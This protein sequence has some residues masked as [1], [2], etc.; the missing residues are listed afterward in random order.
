MPNEN[1]SLGIRVLLSGEGGASTLLTVILTTGALL[2]FGLILLGVI[3]RDGDLSATNYSHVRAFYVAESAIEYAYRKSVESLDESAYPEVGSNNN[4]TTICHIPPGN[5]AN[6]HTISVGNGAVNAHLNHGDY[7]GPCDFSD[8]DEG[9]WNWS[10]DDIPVEGGTADVLVFTTPSN[11]P[12]DLAFMHDTISIVSLGKFNGTGARLEYR[13]KQVDY[14]F[15][16]VYTTGAQLDISVLDHWGN[17]SSQRQIQWEDTPAMMPKLNL[18]QIEQDAASQ[19]HKILSSL[20]LSNNQVY[21]SGEN[22][23]YFSGG[24]PNVTWIEGN[25]NLS[26]NAKIYGIVIVNGSIT[27]AENAT[28]EGVLFVRDGGATRTC[29]LENNSRING[30]LIGFTSISGDN[31]DQCRVFHHKT[32]L[33]RFYEYS[34]EDSPYNIFW[35]EWKQF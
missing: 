5:P 8:G 16:S 2:V 23:F 14:L 6:A 3:K 7:L 10:E 15:Y 4:K 31:P 25:L 26:N 20:S 17:P 28:V 19:G 12:G 29:I 35:Y 21:P 22:D 9:R 27:L 11:E 32:Y 33:Q 13:L 24:V 18:T 34:V 1:R 30:G